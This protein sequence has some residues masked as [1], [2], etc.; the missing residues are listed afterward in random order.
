MG[1]N[2]SQFEVRKIP[3]GTRD[4]LFALHRVM[5]IQVPASGVP[6][7]AVANMLAA[8]QRGAHSI[9]LLFGAYDGNQLIAAV[10]G[11]VSEGRSALV[12]LS[13]DLEQGR[14]YDGTL[15]ALSG[16]VAASRLQRIRLLEVLI[17]PGSQTQENALRASGFRLLTQLRYLRRTTT[18]VPGDLP[19]VPGLKWVS[20]SPDAGPIFEH[21][22][23]L[24]YAQTL[25]CPELSG[26]RP[27]PDV[28][29][30]HRATG[31]F[32]PRLWWVATRANEPIG[33]LLLNRLSTHP[34]LEIVYMGVAQPVRRQGVAHALLRRAVDAAAEVGV[35]ELTLAV[36]VR[37]TPARHA[38]TRWGFTE[39]G[40]RDAWIASPDPT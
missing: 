39:F 4:H 13:G 7:P 30:G 34:A 22:L 2:K 17:S 9:D 28:L 12:L 37:N 21:A 35:K 11:L 26:M 19:E 8:T 14:A 29:A 33:V 38:Y 31:E 40:K 24:T 15:A 27:T 3:V 5:D 36:D 18:P 32:D 16:L 23:E 1:P 10:L 6:A 25:D 20:Y